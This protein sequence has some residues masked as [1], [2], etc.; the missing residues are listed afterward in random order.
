MSD[1][2]FKPSLES[3][4]FV[5]VATAVLFKQHRWMRLWLQLLAGGGGWLKL[6]VRLI[7]WLIS[8]VADG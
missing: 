8:C 3:A 4:R 1:S 6:Y 5:A 2:S 7:M